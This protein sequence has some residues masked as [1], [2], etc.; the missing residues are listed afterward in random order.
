MI[1]NAMVSMVVRSSFFEAPSISK[2]TT[3]PSASI[4]IQAVSALTRVHP[5]P[6]NQ[7]NIETVDLG[8]ILQLHSLDLIKASIEEGV[9]MAEVLSNREHR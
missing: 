6:I 3:A 2:P 8:V 9:V 7:F 5:R 4:D 1:G